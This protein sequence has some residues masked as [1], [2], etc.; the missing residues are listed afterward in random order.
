MTT[1]SM[2][3]AGRDWA[4]RYAAAG[5]RV[6]P[7]EPGTKK[8]LSMFLTADECRTGSDV[9]VW[10]IDSDDLAVI[11]LSPRVHAS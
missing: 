8:G 3:I 9:G 5:W 7:V 10:E 11:G 6:Y 1:D 2:K 4:L